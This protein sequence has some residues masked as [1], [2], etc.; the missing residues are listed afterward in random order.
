MKLKIVG[1]GPLIITAPHT[2]YLKRLNN[3][4]SPYCSLATWYLWRSLDPIPISY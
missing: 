1:N 2:L 4:W 3:R